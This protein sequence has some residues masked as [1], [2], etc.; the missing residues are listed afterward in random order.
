MMVLLTKVNKQ[1]LSPSVPTSV[2]SEKATPFFT[3]VTWEIG[4]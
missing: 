4:E 3:S 1:T 2:P